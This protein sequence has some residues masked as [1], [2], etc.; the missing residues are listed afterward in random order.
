MQGTKNVPSYPCLIL[1]VESD[2]MGKT[3]ED[4]LTLSGEIQSK[5]NKQENIIWE[6]VALKESNYKQIPIS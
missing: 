1:I 5:R 4:A 6:K 2:W 3:F